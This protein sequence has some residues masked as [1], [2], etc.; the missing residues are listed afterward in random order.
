MSYTDFKIGVK[1]ASMDFEKGVANIC[2]KVTN[3][4]KRLG[5][6]VVQVYGEMPQGRLGK[7]SRVLIDLRRQRSLFRDSAMS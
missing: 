4:G 7:P 6:E 2:V 1:H 3:T 5:K